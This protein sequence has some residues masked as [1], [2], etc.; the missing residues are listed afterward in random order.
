M[1]HRRRLNRRPAG[2]GRRRGT[3]GVG[4]PRGGQGGDLHPA[5][6][7]SG[8]D[9]ARGGPIQGADQVQQGG[10]AAAGDPGE[11]GDRARGELGGDLIE[12]DAA[13]EAAVQIGDPDPGVRG[14]LRRNGFPTVSRIGP[15][16]P[17]AAATRILGG[18]AARVRSMPWLGASKGSR[19]RAA[20]PGAPHQQYR[21][22]GGGR[23]LPGDQPG[24][25]P[26]PRNSQ[27]PAGSQRAGMPAP[28]GH[29]R[30]DGG[31]QR[32][33]AAL[34]APLRVSRI[35]RARSRR[36]TAAAGS[37]PPRT[38]R[39][40]ASPAAARRRGNREQGAAA[41]SSRSGNCGRP[42][43]STTSTRSAAVPPVG[44]SPPRRPRNPP[45][46]ARRATS[47][48]ATSSVSTR[49]A[50]SASWRG[51][52]PS[53]VPCPSGFLE[54]VDC[55]GNYGRAAGAATG[56]C[57]KSP[58]GVGGGPSPAGSPGAWRTR[59]RRSTRRCA[60]TRSRGRPRSGT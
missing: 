28:L 49:P 15:S 18:S 54:P 40:P 45:P 59:G 22:Y 55:P 58:D 46:P 17:G 3:A 1:E 11:R 30:G 20:S 38:S 50:P 34:P 60:A 4:R 25:A 56:E 36:Q 10:F 6:P 51:R 32:L 12:D 37:T 57:G 44:R 13:A 19:Y 47:G 33:P 31:Q 24:V 23:R 53:R 43:S 9:A 26:P 41:A 2:S 7:V 5:R 14:L 39:T 52:G 8:D 48:K 16:R 42:R 35:W 27:D 29:G 21:R